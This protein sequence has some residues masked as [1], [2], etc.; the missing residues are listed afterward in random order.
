MPSNG[1]ALQ[2]TVIFTLTF[3]GVM[4]GSVTDPRPVEMAVAQDIE[5]FLG[6]DKLSKVTE[7]PMTGGQSWALN[8]TVSLVPN[9][10]NEVR[11]YVL[12]FVIKLGGDGQ[13]VEARVP[14]LEGI[15]AFLE[16]ERAVDVCAFRQRLWSICTLHK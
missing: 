5:A 3:P 16:P 7:M 14:W 2:P 8:V 12:F 10:K 15:H 9:G 11:V 6:A 4:P 13:A 1:P